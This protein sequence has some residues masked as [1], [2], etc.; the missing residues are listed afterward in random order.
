[1]MIHDSDDDDDDVDD[2]A[3]VDLLWGVCGEGEVVR[4]DDGGA[5]RAHQQA[6]SSSGLFQ[7]SLIMIRIISEFV[8][9]G[10][11]Y[12]R[13]FSSW[14]ELFQNLCIMVRIISEFVDFDQDYFRIFSSWSG[15][16]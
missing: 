13:I 10:E 8:D 9:H 3:G 14:S 4:R 12:F 7:N 15:L 6:W 1:M 16:F 2:D 5:A 11:D